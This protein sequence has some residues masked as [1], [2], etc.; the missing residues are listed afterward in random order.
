M[1]GSDDHIFPTK[2]QLIPEDRRTVFFKSLMPGLFMVG[3]FLF[4]FQ[5]NYLLIV[6]LL[7]V[8]VLHEIGHWITSKLLK[9]SLYQF[10]IFPGLTNIKS[11]SGKIISQSKKAWVILMG[12]VPGIIIGCSLLMYSFNAVES[13]FFFELG[14]LFVFINLLNLLPLDPLD[15]GKIMETIFFPFDSRV[16]LYFTLISSF[17]VIAFGWWLDFWILVGFGF[18]MGLKVRSIQKNQKI[19]DD[20]NEIDFNYNQSYED[21]SDREYWTLRRIFLDHNPKVKELIPNGLEL[22]E[23]E[24]LIFQQVRTLLFN[25]VDLD[26]GIIGKVLVLIVFLL[27]LVAPVYIILQNWEF[28]QAYV[29]QQSF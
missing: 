11:S 26:L 10:D 17:A 5:E 3:F 7:S 16:K 9:S 2:P 4:A 23:N 19:Y 15:G 8:L 1:F 14:M 12:P 27:S 6:Q 22:W 24:R 20:L 18:I 29:E 13:T 21:L 25:R 28:I